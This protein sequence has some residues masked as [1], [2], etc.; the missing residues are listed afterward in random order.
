MLTLYALSTPTETLL[1]AAVAVLVSTDSNL[2]EDLVTGVGSG[3]SSQEDCMQVRINP[4]K[5]GQAVTMKLIANALG[6]KEGVAYMKLTLYGLRQRMM[7]MR[8]LQN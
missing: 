5:T 8:N 7:S 1:H 2:I 6:G 4:S 3:E